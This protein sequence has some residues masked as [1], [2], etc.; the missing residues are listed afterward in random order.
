MAISWIQ[1]LTKN[2]IIT[3]LTE[4]GVTVKEEELID[5]LRLKLRDFVEKHAKDVDEGSSTSG[6]TSAVCIL[7]FARLGKAI[8]KYQKLSKSCLKEM[9][10]EVVLT[11]FR[12][13][14]T[15]CKQIKNQT[16]LQ[17]V[18]YILGLVELLGL[19]C[20]EKYFTD[21]VFHHLHPCDNRYF[22]FRTTLRL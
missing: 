12:F 6:S 3:V 19:P 22:C 8:V 2:T 17:F 21:V 14:L 4:V 15:E 18:M 7:Y 1:Y 11:K 13:S 5:S 9:S 16:M 20:N 10:N